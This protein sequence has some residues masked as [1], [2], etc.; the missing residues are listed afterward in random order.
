[1]DE[2]ENNGQVEFDA[3]TLSAIQN[4]ITSITVS[5]SETKS[6]IKNIFELNEGYLLDPHAAVA[7]SAAIT[8]KDTLP[9]QSTIVCLATAHPAKFPEIIRSCLERGAE[10]PENGKHASLE[11]ASKVCQH[12]RLCDLEHLE[13]ALLDAMTVNTKH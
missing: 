10:L 12:L 5:E 3:D 6:T 4:G 13:F 8:V 9:N 1:M 7:V 2:F 11:N